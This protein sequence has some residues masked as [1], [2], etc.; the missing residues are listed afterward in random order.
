ALLR[1]APLLSATVPRRFTFCEDTF[2]RPLVH[3]RQG[4]S[5]KRPTRLREPYLPSFTAR[6]VPRGMS[7][8]LTTYPLSIATAI[9]NV[10]RCTDDRVGFLPNTGSSIMPAW[11]KP[12]I[13]AVFYVAGAIFNMRHFPFGPKSIG[14]FKRS[15]RKEEEKEY[16]S[17]ALIESWLRL[18]VANGAMAFLSPRLDLA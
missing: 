5:G 6:F 4:Y 16:D 17:T 10:T 1:V 14:Y 12:S 18:N 9:A 13:A 7:T 2:F 3:K 15:S 8:I 11:S